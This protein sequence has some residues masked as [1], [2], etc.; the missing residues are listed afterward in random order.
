VTGSVPEPSTRHRRPALDGLR[1][2]AVTAV[3]AYHLQGGGSAAV[4]RG[5][6]LG[7]DLFFVLSGYLITG[8]LLD[9]HRRDGRIDLR[10]FW[11]RRVRRLFPALVLVLLAVCAWVWWATPVETWA[12]RRADVLATLFYVA[13]WHFVQAGQDYFAAYSGASPL[14][15][16]WSLA[17]EE[18]FYLLWPVLLWGLLALG[19]RL[20]VGRRLLAGVVVAGVLVS[21]VDMAV[22]WTPGDPSRAYYGT[23][24]R[25]QQLFAGALLALALRS[26]AG[27]RESARSASGGTAARVSGYA[28]DL[29]A[30]LRVAGPL[31]AV[32]IVVLLAT[33]PDT[34][35]FYY[36]GGA[37]LFSTLVVAV[38]AEVE[39]RPEGLLARALSWRP[40][41]ALGVISYGVYLWHWP[42]VVAWSVPD[43]ALAAAATQAGRVAVTLAVASTSYLL[44]ER[45]VQRGRPRF[46]AARPRRVALSALVA[47][48][49]V[50]V[51][52]ARATA[53]PDG[54]ADQLA[55]RSDSPCPTEQTHPYS[56]CVK[57]A[58][59]ADQPTL[60]VVGDSTARAF[61]PGLQQVALRRSMTYVQ[62]AWVRCSATGLLV[63]PLG[64]SEPNADDRACHERARD[65]VRGMLAQEHPDLVLVS[66]AWVHHQPV[67]VDGRLV[68]PGTDAHHEAV[69]DALLSLVDD[70]SAA[71]G[72]VVFV[73]LPP[74]GPSV[75]TVLAAGRPA[76]RD[77]PI[78][79]GAA[80]VDGFNEVL[81]E[82]AHE[83]PTSAAVISVTDLVCP[84]GTCSAMV[85]GQVVRYD[86]LHLTSAW[87][88]RVGPTLV[89][90]ALASLPSP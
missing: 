68:Q 37:L 38:L 11:A 78:V 77:R 88:R 17:V 90:R 6:F 54:V 24:G 63:V 76:G 35:A 80:Y 34:A 65:Q 41:V 45:W 26:L 12:A 70:V 30:V 57:V 69:R 53:L 42:I 29:S 20:R 66:D 28:A 89:D 7:V 5:G 15:H 18:Q 13:N 82:V 16:A 19:R 72:D 87:S 43:G 31:A 71:G 48:A 46:A 62:S 27:R 74:P 59:A 36:R 2:V 84:G 49:L 52:G 8:L 1:A 64:Q 85:D 56:Y 79:L 51:V 67:L 25:V 73:E 75:S 9:E 21:A 33:M 4:L 39:V 58:G 83:R 55:D 86:G 32:G 22:L 3:L 61:D 10:A 47:A 44:V 14:R 40:A 60:A 81:H 50:V 23:D